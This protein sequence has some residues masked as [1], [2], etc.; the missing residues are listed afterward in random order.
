MSQLEGSLEGKSSPTKQ[1]TR[2]SPLSWLAGLSGR[3]KNAHAY[4]QQPFFYNRDK[5]FLLRMSPLVVLFA[6]FICLALY[7][8]TDLAT[9]RGDTA[10]DNAAT[11]NSLPSARALIPEV[12]PAPQTPAAAE[13]SAATAP[14]SVSAAETA[15][16][17]PA[18]TEVPL[19]VASAQPAPQSAG[20]F[21]VQVGSY[22]ENEQANEQ[23]ARLNAAGIEARMVK[24][25]LPKRGTWYRVQAGRFASRDEAQR[26]G[27][28][29]QT[30]KTVQQFIVTEVE[31]P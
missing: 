1:S 5:Y 3:Q 21:T 20:N 2:K 29:L 8:L 23:C 28:Q 16:T 4:S 13:P 10:A 9:K 12:S 11:N 26:F 17:P 24:V 19:A 7:S 6:V 14:S 25:E 15:V 30:D 22:G 18:P 27:A 31:V